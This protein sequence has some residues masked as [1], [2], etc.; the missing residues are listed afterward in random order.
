M[1][2]I[3]RSGRR[4]P[5][6]PLREVN[7]R[8]VRGYLCRRKIT[9]A[10]NRAFDR[11]IIAFTDP[12]R[13]DHTVLAV[14]GGYLLVWTLYGVVAKSNQDLHPDMTELIAWSRDLALGFPKHPPLQQSWCADGLLYFRLET[15]LTIYSACRPQQRLYGSLGS[16]LATT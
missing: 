1:A 10:V 6:Q 14:L 12:S 7:V 4:Y 8:K 2:S 11:F 13:R 15:G 16:Y 9:R 3:S 5:R